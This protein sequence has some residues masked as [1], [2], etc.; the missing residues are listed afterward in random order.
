MV[1]ESQEE[2]LGIIM[3]LFFNRKPRATAQDK[4]EA[5][6]ALSRLVTCAKRIETAR[7]IDDLFTALEKYETERH[8]LEL[9]EQK[10]VKLSMPMTKLNAAVKAEIP[11]L[12]RETVDRGYDRL[13]RDIV[14]LKT[15]KG[16][17]N[18]AR[19]FFEELEY[20]YP[21]LQQ[22]TVDH[23]QSLRMDCRYV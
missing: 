16:R 13:M 10:G 21:R 20:Y 7:S 1:L 8:I 18:K 12:E 5:N 14:K 15:E 3:G 22:G 11:R 17:G 6:A 2:T 4:K 19:Q 9:Y 23:I